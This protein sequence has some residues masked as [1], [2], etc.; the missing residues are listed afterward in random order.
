MNLLSASVILV[1]T[2]TIASSAIAQTSDSKPEVVA[3]PA[4]SSNTAVVPDLKAAQRIAEAVWEARF[5]IQTVEKYRP[6]QGHLENDVWHV[7]G[8]AIEEGNVR[9]GGMPSI[10]ISRQDGRVIRVYLAR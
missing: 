3:Q 5:G 10:E 7:W 2:L 4:T 8:T 6:Y 1:T 9:G